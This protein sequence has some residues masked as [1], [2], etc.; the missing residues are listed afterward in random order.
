MV[1]I[2]ESSTKKDI[3]MEK[4]NFNGIMAKFMKV[5]GKRAKNMDMEPGK[6]LQE[7]TMKD[8]G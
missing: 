2:L 4:E 1:N 7:T 8:S 6:A 3:G 5:T